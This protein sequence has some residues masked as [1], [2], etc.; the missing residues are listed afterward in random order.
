[1]E[2]WMRAKERRKRRE[3]EVACMAREKQFAVVF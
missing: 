1:M 2:P 3:R